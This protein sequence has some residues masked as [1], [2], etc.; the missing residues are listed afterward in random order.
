MLAWSPSSTTFSTRIPVPLSLSP[1]TAGQFTRFFGFLV[2]GH[3]N[4]QLGVWLLYLSKLQKSKLQLSPPSEEVL[5]RGRGTCC[6]NDHLGFKL[7]GLGDL[8]LYS[9]YGNRKLLSGRASIKKFRRQ[10][11]LLRV[12]LHDS[13]IGEI[14]SLLVCELGTWASHL[15][16]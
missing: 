13:T 9:R 11:F 4:W 15:N 16:C 7:F 5:P 6:S 10:G 8:Y 1:A 3:S 2:I 14:L 12:P